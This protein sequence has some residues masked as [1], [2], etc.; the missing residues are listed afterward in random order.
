MVEH[1]STFNKVLGD[2]LER[3]TRLERAVP[4]DDATAVAG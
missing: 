2:F 1:A 4:A 3:V